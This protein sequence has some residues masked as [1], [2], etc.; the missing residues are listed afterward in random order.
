MWRTNSK[1]SFESESD[2]HEDGAAHGDVIDD[3]HN[4][5]ESVRIWIEK[6]KKC[7]QK[8]FYEQRRGLSNVGR[9]ISQDKTMFSCIQMSSFSF[10]TFLFILVLI[11]IIIFCKF[12]DLYIRSHL[13]LKWYLKGERLSR[14]N[15]E[16]L[17]A[18]WKRC[19][20]LKF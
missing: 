3:M 12:A 11:Q 2:H 16:Q 18:D 13:L 10:F 19:E 8:N 9:I 14:R 1:V 17:A 6:R 15:K 5:G 7:F 20:V 4:R